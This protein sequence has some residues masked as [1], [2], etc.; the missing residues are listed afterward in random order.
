MSMALK[1]TAREFRAIWKA[2]DDTNRRL[3]ASHMAGR[4]VAVDG[5]RVR[6]ELLPPDGR[7][8]KPFLSPWVQVQE[9]AGDVSSHFP[10]KEGDPMRL[11]SPHGEL[12]PQSIA[13]RDGYTEDRPNPSPEH[14]LVIRHAGNELRLSA[15]GVLIK[16]GATTF[17]LT[18]NGIQELAQ[19]RTI[20]G[21]KF[22]HNG[23]N[24]GDTHK[25]DSVMPGPSYTG[26]PDPIGG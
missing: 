5:D 26:I 14:D 10:V 3:A 7:T 15:Q 12:G 23:R 21:Q 24:V 4:V 6:L 2:I 13:V 1:I 19:V 20:T 16:R 11:L 9:M 18:E 17:L 25:H 8:G 22:S